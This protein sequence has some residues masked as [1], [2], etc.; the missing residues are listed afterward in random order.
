MYKGKVQDM[1]GRSSRC[2][3]EKFKM[4]KGEV[5]SIKGRS[6][7]F[8]SIKCP[9]YDL[10]V[11]N[12]YERLLLPELKVGRSQILK[13]GHPSKLQCR[14]GRVI[15]KKKYRHPTTLFMDSKILLDLPAQYPT[16]S[17]FYLQHIFGI[18]EQYSYFSYDITF[19]VSLCIPP[20]ICFSC[21]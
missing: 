19:I 21:E 16:A 17:I 6:K 8:Y 11:Q 13:N 1:Q 7:L 4:Y 9:L 12:V 15:R 20:T 18:I 10:H 5:Q 3:R 2:T 14:M